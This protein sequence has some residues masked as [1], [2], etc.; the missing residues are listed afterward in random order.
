MKA[1]VRLWK[2]VQPH[3]RAFSTS[4]RRLEQY[5]FIGL[6]QMGFQMARNLQSKLSPSDTVRL[7]D[8]NKEAMERLAQEMRAQ[9]A[10]GAAVQLADTAADAAKEAVCPYV[11][12]LMSL[13]P[14]NPHDDLVFQP[15]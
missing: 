11:P 10:G 13:L 1:N 2:S 6:G 7:Y 3:R 12:F 5:A 14:A 4:P 15:V 9:K 8:L